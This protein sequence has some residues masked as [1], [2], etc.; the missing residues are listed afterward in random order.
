MKRFSRIL[1]LGVLCVPALP[2][3]SGV[4]FPR[5]DI[6]FDLPGLK[7]NPFDITQND[8]LLLLKRPDGAT[9]RLPAFYVGGV[10]WRVRYTPSARGRHVVVAVRNNG[11]AVKPSGL[12]PSAFHV[13]GRPMPGFVRRDPR[14]P[15]RFALDDGSGYYP[16][17]HNA[18][19]EDQRTYTVQG[20][21]AKMG[22]AGMNWSRIWMCHWDL[23]NLD[24]VEKRPV[25]PGTLDLQVARRWDDIVWAAEKSGIRFQMVL[26]HHGQF[27]SGADANWDV[28]PWNVKNGGFLANPADFFTD[29]RARAIT[30]SK[31]RYIIARWGYSP[32][33][34]AWEL[35]NEV[36]WTDA[37]RDGR[38]DDVA[39]WHD[40]MAA[41]IR[42][43]DPY[44]HL[45][46]SSMGTASPELG[47]SL[48]F[49]QPHAYV[50][51]PL[52]AV[53]NL[54]GLGLDRPAFLG[55]IGPEGMTGGEDDFI[56][57]L[58]WSSMMSESAGAAQYWSWE[59]VERANWYHLFRPAVAFARWS[60]LAGMRGA[61]ALAAEVATEARGPLSLSPGG[62]WRK[63]ER[64]EYS[65]LPNGE[66]PGIGLMPRYLQG[67]ANKALF[68]SLTLH[69]NYPKPGRFA[70]RLSQVA[71]LGARVVLSL[72]GAGMVT[73]D[74]PGTGK[75]ETIDETLEMPV[76]EGQH[77]IRIEATGDD[78]V[79]LSRFTFEPYASTLGA[80][81]KGNGESAVVWVFDRTGKGDPVSGSL[82]LPGM[83]AGR[84]SVRWFDPKTGKPSGNSAASVDAAGLLTVDTPRVSGDVAAV[85][86]RAN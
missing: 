62:G 1:W 38:R 36:Q 82:R 16:I 53:G 13:T 10:S 30:R 56:R 77:A 26:Q 39:R 17:G 50:P 18:A 42:A 37:V 70:V 63:A 33:V 3:W 8:V 60:G 67:R 11:K 59:V 29:P 6:A 46:T 40:E 20:V 85:V 7:G 19:W 72:D 21:L 57:R 84:Y 44:R 54:N 64:T 34:M 35:F 65:V 32:A 43:Q 48:D 23:K 79:V 4:I 66:I 52:A 86:R 27:G 47:N 78:W 73:K 2:A 51:D 25:A 24:W 83:R 58:L 80:L 41:F 61:K 55:E 69:V 68:P 81:A 75:D 45:V 49:W 71:R 76:P 22:K 14:D 74:F 5:Q 12:K 15:G 28:N 31:Y 9:V